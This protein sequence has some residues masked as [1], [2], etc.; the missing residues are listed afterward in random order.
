[1]KNFYHFKDSY[2]S[3]YVKSNFE[4]DNE[5]IYIVGGDGTYLYA[6]SKYPLNCIPNVYAF[7]CGNVGMLL[8]LP[9]E[10]IEEMV[11]RIKTAP[12]N[13]IKRNRIYI[14]SHKVPVANELVVKAR[15]LRLITFRITIN[16]SALHLKGDAIIVSTPTG[17]T[18]Y[19]SSLNGPIILSDSIVINCL[20]P[21]R[22]NFK[23]LVLPI[24]TKVRIEAQGCVGYVDGKEI[25]GDIYEIENG[26]EFNI[27]IPDDYDPMT[28]VHQHYFLN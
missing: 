26:D 18:G 6:L 19:N 21:N 17:S 20:A 24:T 27:A 16:G 23:P 12:L 28:S 22:C 25:Q 3:N 11:T 4:E 7:R 5:N 1:M 13:F 9:S 8:P 15:D 14:S 2:Q 10:N